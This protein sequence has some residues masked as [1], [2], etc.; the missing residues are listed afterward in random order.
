MGRAQ[1]SVFPATFGLACCAIE[2]MATGAAHYDLA[3][4]GMEVF[5]ASPRQ[6]DLMIVAGRVSQ[7]MAPVLRQVYD[8]MVEPEVGHLDGRVRQHRRHVQQLRA[9]AGRRPDRPR[10]RVRPRLP[11]RTRD[12]VPR[13]P[14][15]APPDPHRRLASPPRGAPA[16]ARRSSSTSATAPRRTCSPSRSVGSRPE[17]ARPAMSTD[18]EDASSPDGAGVATEPVD[19]VAAAVVEP[20][21]RTAW[22]TTRTARPS[23]TSPPARGTT[24]PQFLRDEQRFTQCVDVTAV[25]HLVDV[26][27]GRDPRR[28]ARSA[29]RSSRTSCPTPGT[30]G[31]GSICEL[32]DD[33]P[34]VASLVDLYSGA[35]FPEREVF[36]LYGI[37]FEGHPDL[38]RILMPDDWVGYPLRKDDA[39]ARIP[40][41]VQGGPG[42][43]MSEPIQRLG[44]REEQRL[45]HQTDEG[46]QE[47]R[48][49][50]GEVV[51]AAARGPRTDDTMILNMGPAAPVD[52]RCAAGHARAR[53]RDDPAL[54]AGDRLPAHRHGEDGRG[55]HLRA[56]R[57]PT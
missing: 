53:R 41:V 27:P 50:A 28:H 8:Q 31:C 29:S 16:P 18:Q 51:S 6:A 55:A 49:T 12:P 39:P 34:T 57:R 23:C 10:R 7:K 35:N 54:E 32:G 43:A 5:R 44:R 11:A 56:G 19:E 4:Y 36:D 46:A 14:H 22:R 45:E 9:R 24:S 3:R 13:D 40:V 30:G 17:P 37:V 20:V 1:R 2:M 48:A 52:P 21:P 38:T 42:A 25:D 33:P 26:E 47:L 15:A